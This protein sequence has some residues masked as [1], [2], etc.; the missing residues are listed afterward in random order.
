VCAK[1]SSFICAVIQIHTPAHFYLARNK[2][3]RALLI[4]SVFSRLMLLQAIRPLP[5]K[6]QELPEMMFPMISLL[7]EL[8]PIYRRLL[9]TANP[10]ALCPLRLL[11]LISTATGFDRFCDPSTAAACYNAAAEEDEICV[12]G[13]CR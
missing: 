3:Q 9:R 2:V 7:V 11:R 12:L 8:S 10:W 13:I 5:C 6:L 4:T 1:K